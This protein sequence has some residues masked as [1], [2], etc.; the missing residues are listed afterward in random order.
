MINENVIVLD[1]EVISV[2]NPLCYNLGYVVVK[3]DGT[4][5][6][7]V[8]FVIEQVWNNKPL[9][10]SAYF[11]DKRPLYVSAMRGR[12]AILT[13]WGYA[14]RT[15]ASDIRKYNIKN[16]FAFNSSFDDKVINFN[17]DYYHTQNPFDNVAVR[18]IRAYACN[19]LMSDLYIDFCNENEEV[20]KAD[21]TQKFFTAN[22]NIATTAES[23]YAFLIKDADYN[24]EHTALADS[25]I[26]AEILFNVADS[27]DLNE[28]DPQV[29][30]CY[31]NPY[32]NGKTLLVKG[33]DG[34]AICLLDNVKFTTRRN[35]N[36]LTIYIK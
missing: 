26:E 25:I 15:L 10:Q 20:K 9:F 31:E 14:M 2:S 8:E 22:G 19:S 18:D 11:A 17:C 23:F 34:T 3:P 12:Q 29:K 16:V 6:K 28:K 27:V 1:T 32:D 5:I 30:R 36:G 24:E 7:K 21:G 13:K 33:A 4:I 35:A